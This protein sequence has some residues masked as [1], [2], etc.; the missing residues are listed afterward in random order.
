MPADTSRF[1]EGILINHSL[2]VASP[3]GTI[4]ENGGSLFISTNASVATY[5][6]LAPGGSY[7][8]GTPLTF[9]TG[10]GTLSL[11]AGAT[12][13]VATDTGGVA[14]VFGDSVPLVFGTGLDVVFTPNGTNLLVTQG[15]GA[16]AL[17]FGDSLPVA[18]GTGLDVML[19]AN[20]TDVVLAQGAGAGLLLLGTAAFV[21]ADSTD[22]TKRAQFLANG[23]TAGQTRFVTLPDYNVNLNNLPSPN[24][25]A[26]PGTGA[27][28][29]VTSSAVIELN[30]GT[31]AET[32]TLANPPA[33][34]NGR[35]ITLTAGVV[36]GGTRAITAAA[37][38]NQAN[39][40]IMTFGAVADF[41][42]LEAI[43]IAGNP[44]WQVV[45]NDG[46][47]LS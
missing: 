46:V 9:T 2:A 33:N 8:Q 25:L 13:V 12:N 23:I 41:I 27:A 36:G 31:G 22:T 28:I 18:F 20:G 40:T 14:L 29:P 15:A 43:T 47:A 16:G 24:G 17:V 39:N 11:T 44:R 38:I 32:N 45:A 10:T 3:V 6:P 37:R 34:A 5:A 19:T 7:P 26:D 21:V 4:I 35:R 1:P 30:I 42:E